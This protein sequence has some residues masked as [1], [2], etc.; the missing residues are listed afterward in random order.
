MCGIS[1]Y[2]KRQCEEPAGRSNP[3]FLC[4]RGLLRGAYHWAHMR[5]TR[6]LAMTGIEFSPI[7]PL[8]LALL[9][10]G[11]DAF[12][13]VARHHVLGHHLRRIAIGV[14]KTHFGLAVERGLAEL[15][16]VGG[17]ERDLLRQRNRGI[18]FGPDGNDAVDEADA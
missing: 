12:L 15:D 18:P 13:G 1:T 8:R 3:V 11:A 6:W 14:G 9:D 16:G 4:V 2:K 17:F 7:L 10:E 5:A